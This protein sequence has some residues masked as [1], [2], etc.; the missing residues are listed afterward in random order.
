MILAALGAIF[1]FFSLFGRGHTLGGRS[2]SVHTGRRKRLALVLFQAGKP[3]KC[4]TRT[5]IHSSAGL[6]SAAE[7]T[8]GRGRIRF[9]LFGVVVVA[10]RK[11]TDSILV[12]LICNGFSLSLCQPTKPKTMISRRR[13]RRRRRRRYLA[14]PAAAAADVCVREQSRLFPDE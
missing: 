14:Q 12:I 7:A 9:L 4:N 10:S 2:L 13:G 1:S 5:C 3:S 6:R 8:F 11:R